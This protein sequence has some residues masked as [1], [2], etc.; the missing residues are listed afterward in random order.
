MWYLQHSSSSFP[1]LF[2]SASSWDSRRA[3]SWRNREFWDSRDTSWDLKDISS[4][5]AERS[6]STAM[7]SCACASADLS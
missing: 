5:D 6:F 3:F 1:L 7:A 4:S 2:F